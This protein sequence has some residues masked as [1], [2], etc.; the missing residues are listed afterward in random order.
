MAEATHLLG[1]PQKHKLN[2]KHLADVEIIDLGNGEILV[3]NSASGKWKNVAL[4]GGGD[5]LKATYDVNENG[6]V[7]DSEKL[8][9]STKA[10]VQNHAPAEHGNEGH[11]PDFASEIALA[12]HEANPDIH[13]SEAHTLESHSEKKLDQLDEKTPDTGVTVDSCLIKDGKVADSNLLEGSTKSQVQIHTPALHGNEVHDPDFSAVGHTHT[14]SEII[15]LDHNAQKI[16]GKTVDD[17]AIG[18]GKVLV[19]RTTG[20][21]LQYE[22]Q[23]GG[24]GAD[25]KV[26][27]TSNDSVAEYLKEKLSAGVGIALTE[28]DDGGDESLKID[29]HREWGW[30][31]EQGWLRNIHIPYSY[32]NHWVD[33][34]IVIAHGSGYESYLN[35]PCV[36]RLDQVIEALSSYPYIIYYTGDDATNWQSSRI[37]IQ[38]SVDGHTFIKTGLTNPMLTPPGA[39]TGVADFKAL[40]DVYETTASKKFKAVCTLYAGSAKSCGYYFGSAFDT[41]TFQGTL[42]LTNFD[43]NPVMFR[44]GNAYF[45]YYEDTSHNMRLSVVKDDFSTIYNH[46]VVLSAGAAGQWDAAR[47]VTVGLFWNLGV[48]YL[49][50]GGLNVTNWMHIGMAYSS[51]GFTYTKYPLNPVTPTIAGAYMGYVAPSLLMV[52]KDF[53]MYVSDWSSGSDFDISRL[54][55]T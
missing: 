28:Q 14:E 13:H 17:A 30:A 18:D 47:L 44:M 29:A 55:L 54:A 35:N 50:Y 3:Y 10:E 6:V 20:D 53:W 25:E 26:K 5:M 33:K 4:P 34:G 1:L 9:G 12:T 41:W 49:F 8:G 2:Q 22:E 24:G 37:W 51:D 23:A 48:W 43:S 52:E 38:K 31:D 39:Y 27:V 42:S 19:Y 40:Y 15:D 32:T 7:D 21:K 46:G 45:I 16:K 11:N 36:L